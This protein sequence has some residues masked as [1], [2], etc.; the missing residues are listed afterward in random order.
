MKAI[1]KVSNFSSYSNLNGLTFEVK[2]V[3]SSIISL[4]IKNVT[5]D[6]SY[7]EVTIVDID[8]E[9]QKAYDSYNWGSDNSTYPRLVRYCEEN[10]IQFT[11]PTY[12]CHHSLQSINIK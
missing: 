9:I 3:L 6:F 5:T 11:K 2:E 4:S 7:K 10:K 12:Y 1:L 8:L